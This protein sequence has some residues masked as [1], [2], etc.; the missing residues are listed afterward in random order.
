MRKASKK[1]ILADRSGIARGLSFRNSSDSYKDNLTVL[2]WWD[3]NQ[4][5]STIGFRPMWRVS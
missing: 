5:Y 4:S 1:A 2:I 3:V